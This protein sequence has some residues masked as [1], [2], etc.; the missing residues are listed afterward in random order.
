MEDVIFLLTSGAHNTSENQTKLVNEYIRILKKKNI[1]IVGLAGSNEDVVKHVRR[2][3][4]LKLV[5]KSTSDELDKVVNKIVDASCASP[6][7]WV[8]M[9]QWTWY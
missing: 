6:G 3:S 9:N 1:T 5:F 8:C 2:W 7:K 4:S